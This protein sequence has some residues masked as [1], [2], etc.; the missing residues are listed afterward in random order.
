M[1]VQITLAWMVWTSTMRYHL[2]E[3]TYLII[4]LSNN[5]CCF[6]SMPICYYFPFD[7]LF[8]VVKILAGA[9]E[10]R[11]NLPPSPSFSGPYIKNFECPTLGSLFSIPFAKYVDEL[12]WIFPHTKT[13]CLKPFAGLMTT[14]KVLNFNIIIIMILS[15]IIWLFLIHWSWS[16]SLTFYNL[17]FFYLLFEYIEDYYMFLLTL[18]LTI[19]VSSCSG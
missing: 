1:V 4:S 3:N 18:L 5:A 17:F 7:Y 2:T 11:H 8:L 6:N 15:L 19:L 14:W 12:L 10:L 13:L 9:K 16:S